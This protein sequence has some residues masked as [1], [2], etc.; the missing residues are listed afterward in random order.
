MLGIVLLL[1][2]VSA[3]GYVA[4]RG[5]LWGLR[6]AAPELGDVAPG[7]VATGPRGERVE[8]EALR[9]KVVLL[10]FWATWCAGCVAFAPV[11]KRLHADYSPHGFVLVGVNQEPGD[12][13]RVRDFAADRGLSYPIVTD[14]GDISEK[15]GVH[16]LPSYVL[17]DRAGR[18][19]AIHHH[20]AS[21]PQLRK[22][23]ETLLS[24]G[25]L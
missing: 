2:I 20:M 24:G 23:I 3:V 4:I 6:P 10:D 11:T 14:P 9:G 7:F 12:D 5:V 18:V 15:Y 17:I 1:V 21:E 25:A 13:A 8:L 19:R 22:Q 16:S